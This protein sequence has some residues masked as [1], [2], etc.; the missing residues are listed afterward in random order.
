MSCR[1]VNA[2]SG[3]SESGG[4]VSILPVVGLYAFLAVGVET[5]VTPTVEV[6]SRQCPAALG[7]GLCLVF[8]IILLLIF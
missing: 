6:V 1:G 7:A 8:H 4:G 2:D 3:F 5:S